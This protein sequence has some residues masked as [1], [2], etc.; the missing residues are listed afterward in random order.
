MRALLDAGLIHGDCL[1]VTGKT[2][3]ENPPHHAPDPDGDIF[4]GDAD[5]AR[6]PRRTHDL[7]GS[8]APEGVVTKNAGIGVDEFVGTARVFER[9]SPRWLRL[10]TAMIQAGDAVVIRYEGPVG[11][12]GMR[13]MLM[14]TG[15]I[16]RVSA[17]RAVAYRWSFPAAARL[18][19]RGSYRAG[20][21]QRWADRAGS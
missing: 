8:L 11:G 7:H 4:A 21:R 6:Y 19:W 13:E 1:T 12:P 16:M 17:G 20:S 9:N 14:I 15:A 3:A 18:A 10:R 5:A 2:V